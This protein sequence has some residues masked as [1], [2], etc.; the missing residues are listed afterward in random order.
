MSLRSK[1]VKGCDILEIPLVRSVFVHRHAFN[2]DMMGMSDLLVVSHVCA[3]G[4][5]FLDTRDGST[6][7]QLWSDRSRPFSFY[8]GHLDL[9][10][11]PQSMLS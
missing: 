1:S 4:T 10:Y 3:R 11:K 8:R 2:T 9:K 7:G 5:V 6:P